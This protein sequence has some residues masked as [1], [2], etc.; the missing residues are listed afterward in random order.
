MREAHC[1]VVDFGSAS[2]VGNA[3]FMECRSQ[4]YNPTLV[5]SLTHRLEGCTRAHIVLRASRSRVVEALTAV[6]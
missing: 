6:D 5:C 1:P 4:M 3:V 2:L